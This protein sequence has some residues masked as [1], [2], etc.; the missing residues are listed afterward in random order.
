MNPF[1]RRP[2][3]YKELEFDVAEL[4]PHDSLVDQYC[5]MMGEAIDILAGL[6]DAEE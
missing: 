2:K 1:R 6:E 3:T 5:A 4:H